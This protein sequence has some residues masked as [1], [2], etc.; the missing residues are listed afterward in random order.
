MLEQVC[1]S[2]GAFRRPEYDAAAATD[3]LDLEVGEMM[4]ALGILHVIRSDADFEREIPACCQQPRITV[5]DAQAGQPA[6]A[7]ESSS[8]YVVFRGREMTADK[9]SGIFFE[10]PVADAGLRGQTVHLK[11]LRF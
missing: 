9:M 7:V 3:V 4:V 1:E 6:C 5:A 2:Y 8:A 10:E 11:I